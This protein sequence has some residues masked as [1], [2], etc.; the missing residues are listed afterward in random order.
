MIMLL[1]V[2]LG[3]TAGDVLA[4]GEPRPV[5]SAVTF[6]LLNFFHEGVYTNLTH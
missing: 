1:A 4:V 3:S 5:A 2:C 6:I